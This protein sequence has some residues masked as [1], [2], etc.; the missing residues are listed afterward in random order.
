LTTLT[1]TKPRDRLIVIVPQSLAGSVELAQN[2]YRMAVREACDVLYLILVGEREASQ[3]AERGSVMMV[4]ET[5]DE[6]ITADS[7]LVEAR[8]WEKSLR[9]LYRP[10][11]RIVCHTEQSANAGSAQTLSMEQ[12]LRSEFPAQVITL[13]GF[14]DPRKEA[15]RPWYR[16][17]LFWGVALIVL[18][19]FTLLEI[20]MD[21]VLQG[22]NLKL[23]L[24]LLWLL[25]IGTVL[26][27]NAVS[28]A[29]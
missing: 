2:I 20:R 11:D 16:S 5:T 27:W 23:V 12:F 1:E 3:A 28:Q 15:S 24:T 4:A 10:G 6:R 8:Q 17:V 9:N 22:W 18:A 14:Y 19:L 7:K 21:Q 26:A 25:E 13:E 29:S